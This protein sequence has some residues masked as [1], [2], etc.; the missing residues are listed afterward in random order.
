MNISIIGGDL[1][2][3][4]LAELYCCQG[5][6]VYVYGLE[7]YKWQQ[8][9][10]KM[11]KINNKIIYNKALSNTDKNKIHFTN[12][13]DEAMEKS[14]IIISGIPFSRDGVKL[15]APYAKQDILIEDFKK[16]LI[17]KQFFA[18]RII[19]ENLSMITETQEHK[20]LENK[21]PSDKFLQN[22]DISN[23]LY[24]EDK[25][26]RTQIYDLLKDDEL[27]ILN[28]I[29]TVEGA[30]K[31]AIEERDETIHE[32]NVLVCGY[33]RIG[34]IACDRFSKL[35]AKVYCTARKETDLAWIREKR[36]IPLT[37]PE[38]INFASKF[39]IIINTVPTLIIRKEEIDAFKKDVLL[40]ELASMPG[41]FDKE[42][43]KQKELKLITA[44][45]IPGKEMPKTAAKYIKK[46]IDKILDT[47]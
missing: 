1:R 18:G 36:F 21:K 16:H 23:D 38:V 33:G 24:E 31:I 2:N 19:E 47:A 20:S 32:S 8:Q 43:I 27:T 45:G 41:G 10:E 7:N 6:N 46:V 12:T 37:Y 44:P 14:N 9:E 13:L 26:H 34:K 30:I 42:Y 35:G 15:N 17:N 25:K 4:R 22:K 3:V 5:D 29:P 28:A 39:D 40:I 11:E